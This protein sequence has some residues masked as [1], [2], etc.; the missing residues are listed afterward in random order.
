METFTKEFYV[1]GIVQGVGFRHYA[2]VEAKKIGVK[3]FVKNL[4]DGRVLVVATGTAVQLSRL[5]SWLHIGSPFGRVSKVE[6]QDYKGKE[7]FK[8]FRPRYE[9]DLLSD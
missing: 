6:V 3:G 9:F 1:S 5:N 7:S 2:S 4:E 8:D